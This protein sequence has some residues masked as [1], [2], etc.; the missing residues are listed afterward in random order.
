MMHEQDDKMIIL[1]PAKL[2]SLYCMD[3]ETETVIDE[4]KTSE[5]GEPS[6]NCA[7]VS[8]DVCLQSCSSR[9]QRRLQAAVG[10]PRIQDGAAATTKDV[11]RTE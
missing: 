11:F 4:W 8:C 6:Q 10:A 9:V 5:Y 2:T 3:V 7:C 1:D